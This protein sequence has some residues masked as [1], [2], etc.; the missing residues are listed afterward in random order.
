MDRHE[1]WRE[2]EVLLENE[3]YVDWDIY[4]TFDFKYFDYE[5]E[6]TDI[7]QE[8]VDVVDIAILKML[9]RE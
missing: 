5:G 9:F 2:G 8:A 1:V 7:E 4:M 3:E 6:Y